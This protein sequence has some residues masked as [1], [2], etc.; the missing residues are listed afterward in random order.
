MNCLAKI[1]LT[2]CIELIWHQFFVL[3]PSG[4]QPFHDPIVYGFS[5]IQ[6]QTLF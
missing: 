4:R 3:C 2:A 5:V 1:S 6:A